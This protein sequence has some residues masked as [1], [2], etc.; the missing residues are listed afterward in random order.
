MGTIVDVQGKFAGFLGEFEGTVL[1]TMEDNR[2]EVADYI[3]E[4][5]YSGVDG[6]E[7]P[8]RPTYRSDP[9]FKSEEAGIWK[10]R[11]TQYMK[12]KKRITPPARSWLGFPERGADTPN[13][14]ITGVFHD[15]I[16]ARPFSKGLK[17][18]SEGTPMGADI[19]RKYGRDIFRVSD[20]AVGHFV[21][22]LLGPRLVALYRKWGIIS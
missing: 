10:G 22:Y 3:R 1:A 2:E 17:I 9:W 15:S 14:I 19:E 13:L 12:W 4:Q 7:K 11:A 8:L 20:K 6:K 21:K 16:K 5:L 18:G